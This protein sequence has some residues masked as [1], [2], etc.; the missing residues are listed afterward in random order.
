[1]IIYRWS[2]R[3]HYLSRSDELVNIYV[4]QT[5]QSNFKSTS[6]NLFCNHY[7]SNAAHALRIQG[8]KTR[9][10]D[11]WILTKHFALC[12][13]MIKSINKW[14][15]VGINISG[16]ASSGWSDELR[17]TQACKRADRYDASLQASRPLWRKPTDE[18]TALTQACRRADRYGAAHS[19]LA[20]TVNVTLYWNGSHS[21]YHI[22]T[23]EHTA[24]VLG[25][26]SDPQGCIVLS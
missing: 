13:W 15:R 22:R 25:N 1:M 12:L 4:E 7:R 19:C 5:K 8:C 14:K 11:C 23:L 26:A 10:M 20:T 2:I 18:Q 6:L 21:Y 9:I 17:L 24:V 3:W 16:K